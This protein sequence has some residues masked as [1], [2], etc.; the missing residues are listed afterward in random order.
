MNSRLVRPVINAASLLAAFYMVAAHAQAPVRDASPQPAKAAPAAA[1]PVAAPAPAAPPAPAVT[2][3]S[4]GDK[5]AVVYDAPAATA[6]K[7][8]IF[9]RNQPLEVLVKLGKWTKVRDIEH[10]VGWVDNTALGTQRFVLVSAPVAEVRAAAS[11]TAALV[12]EAQRGVV[13]EQTGPVADGWLPVR[14]RDGQAGFVNASQV[15]GE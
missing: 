11:A 14:H 7:T 5:P 9:G 4:I 1:A 10:T 12:F 8:F 6:T 2:F 15:W 13:L 3:V